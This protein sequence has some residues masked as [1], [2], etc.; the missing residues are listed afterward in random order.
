MSGPEA[1]IERTLSRLVVQAGGLCYKLTSPTAG[2]PD[3]LV[4]MPGG[5]VYLVELKAPGGRLR[6]VQEAWHAKA[7]RRGVNVLVLGSREEVI[8]WVR[9]IS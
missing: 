8:D 6:K 5:R 1:S 3:R 7:A 4:I 2:V 9:G